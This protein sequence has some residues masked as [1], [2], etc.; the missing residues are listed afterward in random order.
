M[1][2]SRWTFTI[3]FAAFVA[4]P[5]IAQDEKAVQEK[6]ERALDEEMKRLRSELSDLVRREL[7]GS[8]APKGAVDKALAVVTVDLLKKHATFLASDDLEGRN[9]GYP[10]NDKATDYIAGVMKAAGLKPVGDKDGEGA[11]TYFQGFKV[12]G[13]KTRNCAGLIEGSDP[14]LKKQIVVIGAH[15]DHVGTAD[16]GHWG[17]LGS[18]KGEDSIWN[19]ADDNASGTSTVLALIKAFGEGGLKAR[20]TLLFMTFSGEEG[21]LLGSR[22]Y[23]NNPI[24]P[25]DQHVFM[26]NLDMVGRNPDKPVSVEGV[27]SADDG[28]LRRACE[29][30]VAAAG[31]KA[32]ISDKVKLVGGDS[33]HS[34]FRDKGVPFAFFFTGF[35]ADYHR[36]TDHPDRLAYDNMVKIANASGRI[37]LAIGDGEKSPRFKGFRF[38]DPGGDRPRRRLGFTPGELS[39]Q[40]YEDLGLG[41]AEGAMKIDKVSAGG[42]AEAAGLKSGD[43]ILSVNGKKFTRQNESAEL[44][45]ILEEIEARKEVP[46]VVIRG[47]D[48]V[49][50]KA[51]WDK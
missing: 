2:L 40:D 25:I 5:C 21:G 49:S 8:G 41:K 6:V 23:C 24:A 17:R 50:L 4:V 18:S 11:A 22:H 30:A 1:S 26:L 46:I 35:H 44:R 45:T 9:A 36:V 16:Q 14:E 27:G 20:R 47:K 34:S 13:R 19:G 43:V 38:S 7:G 28:I 32:D 15:H 31:L 33:D 3:L 37:L 10:G 39:A 29:D 12:A 51:S 42:A 48:R